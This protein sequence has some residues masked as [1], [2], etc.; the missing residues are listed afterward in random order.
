MGLSIQSNVYSEYAEK[1]ET[2]RELRT[3]IW[4]RYMKRSS[5]LWIKSHSNLSQC[6]TT[7]AKTNLFAQPYLKNSNKKL[8]SFTGRSITLFINLNRGDQKRPLRWPSRFQRDMLKLVMVIESLKAHINH[9]LENFSP[10]LA[11]RRVLVYAKMTLEQAESL[12][13]ED[14]SQISKCPNGPI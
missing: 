13:K 10:A 6:D 2:I 5:I 12:I 11:D 9:L 3:A 4:K 14:P 1:V 8:S 7:A